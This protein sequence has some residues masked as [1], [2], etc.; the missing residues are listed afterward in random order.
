[1]LLDTSCLSVV[2]CHV[3][4]GTMAP[5][6]QPFWAR[7]FVHIDTSLSHKS[8]TMNLPEV[9]DDTQQEPSSYTW[10]DQGWGWSRRRRT[11]EL[12]EEELDERTRKLELE[13]RKTLEQKEE[14]LK[15]KEEELKLK[16]EEELKL[17]E[18]ELEN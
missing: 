15:L 9:N 14:E 10:C 5:S 7:W 13:T 17:K 18:E 3:S 12:E 8:C 11:L 2:T 1:M 16:E 4:A 6:L